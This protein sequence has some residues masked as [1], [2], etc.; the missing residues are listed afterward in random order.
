MRTSTGTIT[1][2]TWEK[3]VF[4]E[5]TFNSDSNYYSVSSSVITILQDGYY[6][7]YSCT[8]VS[9]TA[10]GDSARVSMNVCNSANTTTYAEYY[11]TTM[12][13]T[14]STYGTAGGSVLAYLNANDTI[15]CYVAVTSVSAASSRSGSYLCI[16]KCA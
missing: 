8:N 10:T 2:N 11:G 9:A 3:F 16:E 1:A 6:R 14:G 13:Y 15:C 5:T 7:I 4:T 12:G